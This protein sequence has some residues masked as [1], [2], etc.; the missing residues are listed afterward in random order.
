MSDTRE[1]LA[2]E[3]IEQLTVR[4]ALMANEDSIALASEVLKEAVPVAAMSMAHLA[5]HSPTEMIR[6]NAAKY[7]MDRTMGPAKDAM[8]DAAKP[9]WEAIYDS[10]LV[11]AEEYKEDSE[12]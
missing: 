1:W 4:R 7:I 2:D 11:Q 5:I 3:A 10:V 12:F 9:A 8:N 6:L